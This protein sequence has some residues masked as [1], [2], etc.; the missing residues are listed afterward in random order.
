MSVFEFK[1]KNYL[2][3]EKTGSIESPD[4]DSA[5]NMLRSQDLLVVSLIEKKP[6]FFDKFI[7]MG[8]V[9]GNE[10][11]DF[12]RQFATMINSGL[13][14]SKSLQISSEQTTSP[15][16]RKILNEIIREVDAGTTLSN[17]MSKYSSVF[18]ISY[19]SLVKAG[20][21]SGKLDVIMS[22]IADAYEANRDLKSRLNSAMIYPAIIMVIMFIVITILIVYVIPK[23]TE[24]F[25]SL[26]RELPLITQ[27]L[28]NLSNFIIS[29]WYLI[30]LVATSIILFLRFY[31][32]TEKGRG[33][34]ASI[35]LGLPVLGK[36]IKQTELSSYMR[37]LSLL[38]G[39]GVQLTEALIITSRVSDIPKLSNASIEA[40]KFVEKGNS[41]SSYLKQNKFFEPIIA[42]MVGI[43]EETG[44]IDELLDKVAN[45]YANESGYAI[46]GLSSAIEPIILVILGVSVGGIILALI[47][48]IFSIINTVGGQ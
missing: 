22:R 23:L 26:D 46:K 4:K 16:F 3:V 13:T 17:A 42:S 8:G 39:S 35:I 9:G 27:L 24:V 18:D 10:V 38:V 33:V 47:I 2:G 34:R 48:P 40:S 43:G 30:L 20:E 36:V 19:T 11:V 5:L 44:K 7:S 31:F 28:V 32:T 45:N 15:N 1:A 37:T 41:L 12:S 21:S 25:K 29:Y 6:S 14:V